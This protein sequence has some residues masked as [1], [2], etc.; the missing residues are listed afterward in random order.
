[1]AATTSEHRFLEPAAHPLQR[2]ATTVPGLRAARRARADGLLDVGPRAH[3]GTRG[4]RRGRWLHRRLRLERLER[5]RAPAAPLDDVETDG[6]PGSDG[7]GRQRGH[8][9]RV[10]GGSG[11]PGHGLPRPRRPGPRRPVLAA[12][13]A[14]AGSNGGATSQG[15]HRH[16]DQGRLPGAQRAGLP[17]DPRR[18]RRRQPRRLPRHDAAT[19]CPRSPTTSTSAS[20]STAARSRSSSTTAGLQHQR[21][22]RQGPRQGRGR[23]H[24]GGRGDRRLRRPVRHLRA[25]RR[26]PGQAA[27]VIGFGTPYLSR[28]WHEQRAP[29]RLEP[30]HRRLERVRVRRR[31]SRPSASPA[32]TPTFAG[33]SRAR[34]SPGCSPRSPPR[35][36]GTRSR[37]KTPAALSPT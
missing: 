36:P 30:R 25:L 9:R 23:R 22:A 16:H 20:S 13:R 21:A 3:E 35:T 14:F 2:L 17:A 19:P 6:T 31:V 18:A 28:A 24:Q 32:A 26:R 10:G 8:A 34:A 37:C 27:G 1:M 15:R 12:L 4:R 29:V 5:R 11:Q 33:G 7:P